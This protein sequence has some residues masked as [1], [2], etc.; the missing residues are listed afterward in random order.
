[1]S[2]QPRGTDLHGQAAP[3][4]EMCRWPTTFVNIVLQKRNAVI[5]RGHFTAAFEGIFRYLRQENS[6]NSFTCLTAQVSADP[7]CFH[8]FLNLVKSSLQVALHLALRAT[9][10]KGL[11]MKTNQ[12][13]W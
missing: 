4:G 10:E 11:T 12:W 6:E 5:V 3:V 2:W 13:L 9:A 7:V 8:A 1:M